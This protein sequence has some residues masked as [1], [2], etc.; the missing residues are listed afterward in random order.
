MQLL[1]A[2][3]DRH[4]LLDELGADQRG[5]EAG[6]GAGEEHAVAARREAGLGFHAAE[7][8]DDLLGLPRVV[9]L[10]VLP[11]NLAVLHCRR[12]DGGGPDVD[13]DEFHSRRGAALARRGARPPFRRS[14][15]A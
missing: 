9:P 13:A 5:Q 7:E 10:V 14:S 11:G 2:G 8:L 6:A 15:H 12:L 4:D 1:D 3:G